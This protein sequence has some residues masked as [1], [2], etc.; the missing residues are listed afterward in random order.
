MLKQS[1]V[2]ASETFKT[3]QKK[4]MEKISISL[5]NWR[6]KALNYLRILNL[7]IE[8]VMKLCEFIIFLWKQFNAENFIILEAAAMFIKRF[9]L[10]WGNQI[11]Y[12]AYIQFFAFSFFEQEFKTMSV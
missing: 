1:T 12:F 4:W 6:G 8:I 7:W 2:V 11:E 9:K 3:Q 5:Y 10:K